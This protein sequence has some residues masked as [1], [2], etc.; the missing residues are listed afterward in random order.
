VS[1]L[2][3]KPSD[4]LSRDQANSTNKQM[5][6]D[7]R[8]KTNLRVATPPSNNDLTNFGLAQSLQRVISDVSVC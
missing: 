1:A 5:K 7:G 6:V 2:V 4:A 3:V 8:V